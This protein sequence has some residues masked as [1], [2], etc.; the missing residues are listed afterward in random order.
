M[1]D[2]YDIQSTLSTAPACASMLKLSPRRTATHDRVLPVPAAAF[3]LF[4]IPFVDV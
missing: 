1:N 3:S 4:I 2:D